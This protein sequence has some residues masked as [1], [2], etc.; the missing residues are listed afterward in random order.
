MFYIVFAIGEYALGMATPA[1][2]LLSPGDPNIHTCGSTG[3]GSIGT[4]P[5]GCG[6]DHTSPCGY[7]S[8]LNTFGSSDGWW[9]TASIAAVA[10]IIAA[11]SIASLGQ[12]GYTMPILIFVPFAA[13]FLTI[14]SYPSAILNGTGTPNEV[15]TLFGFI[16]TALSILFIYSLV[17]WVKGNE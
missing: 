14:V 7:A 15:R 16:Y 4:L 1:T 10:G 9:F 6:N 11:L 2:D 12:I 5:C 3:Y 13:F 17:S 8:L